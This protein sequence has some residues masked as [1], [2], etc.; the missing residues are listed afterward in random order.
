LYTQYDT[1]DNQYSPLTGQV[2]EAYNVAFREEL[3]G[4]ESFDA[5]TVDYRYFIPFR[6]KH[7]LGLHVKGRWTS[8]APPSGYSSVDLRGYTRGQYLAPHMTMGEADYRHMI[9][10]NKFGTAVFSGV[11]ILYGDDSSDEDYKIYPAGGVGLFYILNDEK[12]VVRAD[13]AYGAEGNYGFYLQLG[14]PF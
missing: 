11:A 9:Y 5:L 8:D 1:R 4:D 13:V 3:G 7:T 2:F 6:Q 10:K 12:M 14:Q